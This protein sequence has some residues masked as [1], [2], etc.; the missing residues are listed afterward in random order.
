VDVAALARRYR[1]V[2][3]A[4]VFSALEGMGAPT[5]LLALEIRPIRPDQ[6]VA[7]PAFTLKAV[8]DPR[9][10]HT[11][12]TEVPKLGDY[13]MFRAMSPG[14][15]IVADPG[16]SDRTGFWGD[17]MSAAAQTSGATGI[18][19]DGRAR[20][21]RELV[22]MDG[23]AVFCRGTT[24]S[25]TERRVNTV[26]F[27]LPVTVAGAFE[28]QVEVRPGDWVY[29]DLDGVIA[30]PPELVEPVLAAAEEAERREALI[31]ADFAAGQK[32]W[33]VYPKHRRL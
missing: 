33:D 8:R 16:E 32:V 6:V 21:S 14:C 9:T 3:T 29:G 28:H 13:A 7:G 1:A 30:I 18:V 24:M 25:S 15:V 26:D 12:E 19:I 23:F 4:A 5:R 2:G 20:D 11:A 17:L 10:H 31:R 22:K 27:Q